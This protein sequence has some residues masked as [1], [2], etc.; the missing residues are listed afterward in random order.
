MNFEILG[1]I[2]NNTSLKGKEAILLVQNDEIMNKLKTRP[3]FTGIKYLSKGKRGTT[4]FAVLED[5]TLRELQTDKDILR[6]D[7]SY[8]KYG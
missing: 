4:V 7:I 6:Y 5:I 3:Q 1:V 8:N 2:D